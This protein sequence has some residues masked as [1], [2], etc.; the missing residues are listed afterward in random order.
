MAVRLPQA[1]EQ[2]TIERPAA[3]RV[4]SPDDM[5]ETLRSP[6][7]D[8]QK[9]LVARTAAGVSLDT[10]DQVDRWSRR[11][12]LIVLIATTTTLWTLIAFGVGAA[13][14]LIA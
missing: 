5:V 1:P 6:A 7:R 11:T 13:T 9:L 4:V 14:G 3:L 2:K 12:R 8:L 10:P